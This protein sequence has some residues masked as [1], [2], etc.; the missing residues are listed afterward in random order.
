MFGSVKHSH[1]PKGST[2]VSAV[3]ESV[4]FPKK[5]QNLDI[6]RKKQCLLSPRF[7]GR[8]VYLW[9]K[10]KTRVWVDR[11]QVYVVNTNLPEYSREGI[12]ASAELYKNDDSVWVVA[13]EDMIMYRGN[14]L[15]TSFPERQTL[16]SIFVKD[17]HKG[18]DSSNDPGVFCIKPWYIPSV[19]PE[20]IRTTEWKKRPEWVVVWTE[21]HS[22]SKGG[23]WF[24]KIQDSSTDNVYRIVRANDPNPDQ[25]DILD[26]AGEIISRVSVRS[27]RI[28]R[29]LSTLPDGTRVRCR[30]IP[31]I[32]NPE[33]Y[34][35]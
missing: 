17:L 20:K 34:E 26:E 18:A 16:L 24:C 9:V 19:F 25:Y 32:E 22:Q 12:L 3:R 23:F 8:S 21:G 27:L 13:F 2:I 29:W 31:G 15:R 6:L 11:N 4:S 10:G 7:G 1:H 28:S 35:A 14:T 30:H 5:I 33:P